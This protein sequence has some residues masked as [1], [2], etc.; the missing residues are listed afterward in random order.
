MA[1]KK[2][3]KRQYK[4][5]YDWLVGY[6]DGRDPAGLMGFGNPGREYSLEASRIVPLLPTVENPEQ[7]APKI[8]RVF[9]D[10]MGED[11]I[12]SRD[13]YDEIAVDIYCRWEDVFERY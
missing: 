2:R 6:L 4:E 8:Y 10:C 11:V 5:F 13:K 7:L 3:L 1:D 9:A 12:G